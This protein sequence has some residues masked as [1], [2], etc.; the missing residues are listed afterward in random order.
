MGGHVIPNVT[1]LLDG[2]LAGGES[3]SEETVTRE[4]SGF[5][6]EEDLPRKKKPLLN[7]K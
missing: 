7:I 3:H 6:K 5:L 2:N 4:G 1:L